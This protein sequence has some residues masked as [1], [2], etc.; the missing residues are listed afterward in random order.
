MYNGV[1]HEVTILKLKGTLTFFKVFGIEMG[2]CFCLSG[3]MKNL[4]NFFLTNA[5]FLV[6]LITS[7]MSNPWSLSFF[8]H[9]IQFSIKTFFKLNCN[10]DFSP[11]NGLHE[12]NQADYVNI[13]IAIHLG[14]YLK[15]I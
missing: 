8:Q 5:Y 10:S 7:Q 14:N 9:N 15:V 3:K 11:F 1:Q 2:Q 12:D 13:F 6:V 4:D